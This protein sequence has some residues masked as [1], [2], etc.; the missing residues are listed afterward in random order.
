MLKLRRRE[1]TFHCYTAD[2]CNDKQCVWSARALCLLFFAFGTFHFLDFKRKYG[3]GRSADAVFCCGWWFLRAIFVLV[4]MFMAL[5]HKL[6]CQDTRF[7]NHRTMAE[8]TA[9]IETNIHI[10]CYRS[11]FCEVKWIEQ[12]GTHRETLELKNFFW[13]CYC[14]F[15]A[16]GN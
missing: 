2:S 4:N 1:I 12:N 16:S 3:Y 10:F 5:T 13:R 8:W 11:L 15:F 14:W 7:V 6:R 9:R